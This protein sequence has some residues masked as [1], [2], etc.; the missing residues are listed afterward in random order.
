[1]SAPLSF[2]AWN[3]STAGNDSGSEVPLRP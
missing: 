2:P 3:P 1:V